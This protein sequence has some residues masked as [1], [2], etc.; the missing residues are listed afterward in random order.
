MYEAHTTAQHIY[1]YYKASK[2]TKEIQGIIKEALRPKVFRENGYYFIIDI[3][4]GKTLL[5]SADATI[6]G[7]NILRYKNSRGIEVGQ[8]MINKVKAEQE[9]FY[10]YFWTKPGQG[11]EEYAKLSYLKIF[12]PYGWAIGSGVYVDDIRSKTQQE[13]L[14]NIEQMKFD[15]NSNNYIFIGQ[16]NGLS[17]SYPTKGKNMYDVQDKNGLYI[18]RELIKTSKEGGGF[19]EYVMPSLQ[20]ERNSLKLSYTQGIDDWGWYVGA[21]LYVDD[22]NEDIEALEKKMHKEFISTISLTTLLALVSFGLFI[23]FVRGMNKK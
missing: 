16:W 12:E 13:V 14:E 8:Q 9:T 6:E 17:L 10:E 18:V 2:S 15:P 22:I 21:G 7:K 20:N 19:V 23:F 11:A 5:N 4:T 3:K 1:D